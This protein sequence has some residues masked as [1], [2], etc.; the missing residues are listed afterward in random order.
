MSVH[1]WYTFYCVP[2]TVVLTRSVL[3]FPIPVLRG[4]GRGAYLCSGGGR[5]G[6]PVLRRG[7][8]IPVLRGGG[9]GGG[10]GIPVL[11]RGWGIPVLRGGEGGI[12]VLRGGW[13][14]L[15]VSTGQ[16]CPICFCLVNFYKG[17]WLKS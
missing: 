15:H 8:G 11:R 13:G 6:I 5:G 2:T 9:G 7:W 12:P 10:G 14:P 4:G 17:D 3:T 16:T 1:V